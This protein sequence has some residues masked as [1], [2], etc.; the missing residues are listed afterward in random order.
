MKTTASIFTKITFGALIAGSMIACNKSKTD[1]KTSTAKTTV[2]DKTEIVF[3]N[4][5]S[6]TAKYEYAKDMRKRLED[7]GKT[8]QDDVGG[9]KQAFQRE[10]SDY[11][12]SANTLSADQR[13]ATE[14]RLQ[15]EGQELQTYEQNTSAQFQSEQN[16]ETQ[17]LYQKVYDFTKQYA[18]EKGYKMVLTFQNG[19]PGLLYA[20]ESVDVTVDVIKRLNEAYAKDKK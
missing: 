5:D 19:N 13:A 6:L 10:V 3:I 12:K 8:A 14:Q 7:K 11:Q 18:K 15:R 2:A 20:D 9:R 4:Q 16:T 17:K 1:D